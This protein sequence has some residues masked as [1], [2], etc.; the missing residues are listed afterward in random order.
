MA[1]VDLYLKEKK[2]KGKEREDVSCF[3]N[4][5]LKP[6]LQTFLLIL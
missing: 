2:K 3:K 5:K 4:G 1:G 6:T